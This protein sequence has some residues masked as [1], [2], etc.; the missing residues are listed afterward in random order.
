MLAAVIAGLHTLTLSGAES[1]HPGSSYPGASSLALLALPD[2][3]L[4]NIAGKL[5][6]DA[7]RLCLGAACKELQAASLRWFPQP[8]TFLRPFEKKD[9]VESLH[10]PTKLDLVAEYEIKGR[11][12]H[13]ITGMLRQLSGGPAAA[14]CIT[15][16]T[17]GGM[18]TVAPPALAPFTAL[19]RLELARECHLGSSVE[20]LW[21]LTGLQVLAL[22]GSFFRDAYRSTEASWV[23]LSALSR[24]CELRLADCAHREAVISQLP[25]LTA[26]TTLEVQSLYD[27]FEGLPLACEWRNFA[28]LHLLQRLRLAHFEYYQEH[29]S[30][31][32]S[33]PLSQHP[34]V[35]LLPALAG[36]LR[37]LR[38]GALFVD[39]VPTQL[40]CCT[41]LSELA[42]SGNLSDNDSSISA[43][44][45]QALAGLTGMQALSLSC[46][47]CRALP[48]R[49]LCCPSSLAWS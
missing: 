17:G 40:S 37:S 8:S 20:A 46:A 47:S 31:P 12:G 22:P 43:S 29:L 11:P 23:G 36:S 42:I 15:A 28:A 19:R 4:D 3:A 38:L 45:L 9:V 26:L 6:E 21:Q 2:A 7:D 10:S 49:W 34:F 44:G 5:P 14:A 24:L 30:Q 48:S 39:D 18:L 33:H 25:A 41:G 13:S 35:H 27:A 32:L 1:S 16:V